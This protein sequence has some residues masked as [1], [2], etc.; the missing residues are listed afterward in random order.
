[1]DITAE[2]VAPRYAQDL[3]GRQGNGGGGEKGKLE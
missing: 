3:K 1:M 2:N